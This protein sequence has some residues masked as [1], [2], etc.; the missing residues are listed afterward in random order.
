MLDWK[1]ALSFI[2]DDPGDS[3]FGASSWTVSTCISVSKKLCPA[4]ICDPSSKN[5]FWSA[6]AF[7]SSSSCVLFPIVGPSFPSSFSAY[8]S[9]FFADTSATGSLSSFIFLSSPSFCLIELLLAAPG[10]K[11]E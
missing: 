11:W 9:L 10:F 3:L 2:A 1:E 7:S 6:D 8:Y 5:S 4:L